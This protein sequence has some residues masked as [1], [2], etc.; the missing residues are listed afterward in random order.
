MP[1]TFF[2]RS[3]IWVNLSL[4]RARHARWPVSDPA[5]RGISVRPRSLT[6]IGDMAFIFTAFGGVVR[7]GTPV[8]FPM[9][10]R[11]MFRNKP[12]G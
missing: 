12:G 8:W 5:N 1:T 2:V 11:F 6:G 4:R 3:P 10:V 7:E 9:R